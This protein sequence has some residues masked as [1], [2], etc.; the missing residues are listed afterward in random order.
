MKKKTTTKYGLLVISL[1]VLGGVMSAEAG[2]FGFG[3]DSWNEEVLLHDGSKIVVERSVVRKGRH[4]PFQQPTI[5]EQNLSFELP[6]THQRVRWK[7]E[8]SEDLGSA[9]FLPM[10]LEIDK[11]TAYL[12]VLPMGCL[13]YNKWG[14]PNP[15]YVVFKF[16][17]EEWQRIALQ[18]LPARFK[19]PNL[20]ISSP[21]DRV[22][23]EGRSL[24]SAEAVS[25]INNTPVAA[26]TE[27]P[28]LKQIVREPLKPGSLGVNCEELVFYKGAWVGPGDSIGRRMMDRMSK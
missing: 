24:I 15:P 27:Q 7:D 17:S 18:E 28:H 11:G 8:Y 10:T 3:G 4:E 13:S 14:R 26:G 20:I 12:V 16:Q 9:N 6:A 19:T 21:D 22:K 25:R 5:G 23:K 2:L 1:M